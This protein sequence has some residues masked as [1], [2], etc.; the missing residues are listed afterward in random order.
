M[1]EFAINGTVQRFYADPDMP[2]LWAIL[3][4]AGQIFDRSPLKLRA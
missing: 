3:D 1:I 2:L 4:T